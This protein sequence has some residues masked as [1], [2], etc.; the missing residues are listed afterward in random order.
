MENERW[1]ETEEKK[2]NNKKSKASILPLK[3]PKQQ[4][5]MEDRYNSKHW[6]KGTDAERNL[7]PLVKKVWAPI[8]MKNHKWP[9]WP[10]KAIE[11]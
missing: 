10:L 11:P 5:N 1:E 2:T 9:P 8:T 7:G 6:I 3:K 4:T